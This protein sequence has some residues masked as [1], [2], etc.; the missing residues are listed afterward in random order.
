MVVGVDPDGNSIIIDLF[1]RDSSFATQFNTD[2]TFEELM[3]E[4]ADG[5]FNKDDTV[6]EIL[7][8]E[9]AESQVLDDD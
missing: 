6:M 4:L 2:Y 9:F 8:A 3:A 1:E 5:H 7:R